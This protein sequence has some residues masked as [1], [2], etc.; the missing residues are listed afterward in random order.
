VYKLTYARASASPAGGGLIF[1]LKLRTFSFLF[2]LSLRI[3]IKKSNAL[4]ALSV[5]RI[6]DHNPAYACISD[7]NPAYAC[8]SNSKTRANAKGRL[9]L[10]SMY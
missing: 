6:S 9:L 4:G 5:L 2:I 10:Y 3:I 1:N 7:H 8:E